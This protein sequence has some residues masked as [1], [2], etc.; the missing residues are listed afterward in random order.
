MTPP[1]NIEL[2]STDEDSD[3]DLNSDTVD[4]AADAKAN[5]AGNVSPQPLTPI[6]LF[7][8]RLVLITLISLLD[9]HRDAIPRFRL[10]LPFNKLPSFIQICSLVSYKDASILHLRYKTL[11]ANNVHQ[12]TG[13]S[14]P[15]VTPSNWMSP[16]WVSSN[17]LSQPARL[18]IPFPF[19]LLLPKLS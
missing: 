15:R 4:D 16:S 17:H 9:R 3:L 5:K 12:T 13:S 8:P 11:R 2:L 18:C 7:E 10:R 6:S 1:V 19:M 14:L